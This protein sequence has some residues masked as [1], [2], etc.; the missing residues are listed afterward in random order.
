MT[1]VNARRPARC[2]ARFVLLTGCL[3]LLSCRATQPGPTVESVA[4][5]LA[6]PSVVTTDSSQAAA[7]PFEDVSRAVGLD[8]SHINGMQGDLTLVEVIGSGVAFFDYDND[9]DLDIYLVQGHPLAPVAESA[10]TLIPAPPTVDPPMD[11]LYRNDLRTLPDGTTTLQFTDVTEASGIRATGY[12]MGVATGD[13][14][15][16]GWMDLYVTN[17]G[18]NQLWRN[19]GDGSFVDVTAASGTGDP[20]W[21]TAAVFVDV[22]R[23]R[24]PDLFVV[25]YLDYS[26]ARH[27]TCYYRDGMQ[28]EDYCGVESYNPE[29]AVLYRNRGDGSFEDLSLATGVIADYGPGLGVV[30]PDVNSDGWPDLYVA[31]DRTENLLWV[32][33][34]G[35][36]FV[37]EARARG[38]AVNEDG[39]AE[40]GM[41][42]ILADLTDDALE[43]IFL[44]HFADETN[45]LYV[46]DADGYF[47]DQSDESGLGLPS[48]PFTAF[49]VGAVD[50][51]NDGDLDIATLNGEVRIILEQQ[52]AGDPFPVK[53]RNQL[54]RNLGGGQFEE[55]SSSAGPRLSELGVGRGLAVGDVDNDGDGDILMS[56]NNGPARLLLNTMGQDQAWIGL[57]L[58]DGTPPRDQV[59]ARVDLLRGGGRP[60]LVRRVQTASGYLSSGDPRVL[61]GLGDDPTFERLRVTWPSGEVEEWPSM[62]A[63]RYQ[64]LVRGRGRPPS[65]P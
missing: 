22:D 64:T 32:N 43:D 23:D 29:P 51:E 21:S 10:G 38:V 44:T 20:R 31:N 60:P 12:G 9:G 56:D 3:G 2:R 46:P 42:V 33:Q 58:V 59:G 35:K 15:Q 28:R 41:G 62:E 16:D 18:P 52:A 50:L 61:F 37:N 7:P 25:N 11:R 13:Y 55:I 19:Q 24:W 6:T 63:G 48:L 65:A 57:R 39:L 27:R 49:G 54:F 14:D 8:F 36:H 45:T 1:A 34:G 53:Q 5:A 4:L 40:A 47:S 30:A 26:Y 17:W